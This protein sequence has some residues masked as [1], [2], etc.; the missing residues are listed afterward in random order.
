MNTQSIAVRDPT[1]IATHS[2]AAALATTAAFTKSF[3]PFQFFGSNGVFL[4][5][6]ALALIFA[7]LDI[8]LHARVI[9]SL[10][11][12][13]VLIAIF[14]VFSALNFLVE[15]ENSVPTTYLVGMLGLTPAFI[16]LGI[17]ASSNIRAMLA[18][19]LA[20]GLVYLCY[21]LV[22]WIP[23]GTLYIDGYFGDIFNLGNMEFSSGASITQLYQNV[24]TFLGAGLI[25]LIF[26]RF[27]GIPKK[28]FYVYALP[29]GAIIITFIIQAQA[30]GA[31]LALCVALAVQ[32]SKTTI[33]NAFGLVVSAIVIVFLLVF[34]YHIEFQNL[35]IWIRTTNELAHPPA[36]SRWYLFSFAIDSLWN[37]PSLLVFGRGLGMFPVDIGAH[38]PDW[39]L[40]PHGVSLYPHNPILEALYEL[41]IIGAALY[42]LII[43]RPFA[44]G[45]NSKKLSDDANAISVLYVFFLTIE[46]V[47]G[48]LAY[49]FT[50]FFIFGATIGALARERDMAQ[51]VSR[52]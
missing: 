24:G 14:F 16:I 8:Q 41:G 32:S 30:R 4:V 15:T 29:A 47:S 17:I 21:V 37:N 26:F 11:R 6:F 18:T 50:F 42:T 22:F 48:S 52:L 33:W 46:M 12:D 43:V 28:Y 35:P 34:A 10:R 3:V 20:F 25:A 13:C 31:L 23:H 51:G 40:T 44:S 2:L 9:F 27:N 38:A 45:F 19:S 5:T 49:S 1:V 39:L 36:G 7:L